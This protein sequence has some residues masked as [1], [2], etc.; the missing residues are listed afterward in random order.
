[1]GGGGASEG[2][3]QGGQMGGGYRRGWGGGSG[4]VGWSKKKCLSNAL[5]Y[6]LVVLEVL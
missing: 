3:V 1:M 4:R 5:G 6:T 2:G